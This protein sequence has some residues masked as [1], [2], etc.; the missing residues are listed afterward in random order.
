MKNWFNAAWMGTALMFCAATLPAAETPDGRNWPSTVRHLI[1]NQV[2]DV[3]GDTD[4]EEQP[5]V[6]EDR[7]AGGGD[8]RSD[9][10][11]ERHQSD[12]V[13]LSEPEKE[14]GNRKHGDGKHQRAAELL[15]ASE[16]LLHR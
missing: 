3:D 15:R 1:T 2:I 5:E 8:R 16:D 4:R 12:D 11:Q 14:S 6:G 9:R 7:I 13:G 10:R